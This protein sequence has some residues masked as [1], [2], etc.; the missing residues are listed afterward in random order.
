MSLTYTGRIRRM[1][2]LHRIAIPKQICETLGYEASAP[3]E[4]Y[5][6]NGE[7]AVIIR[8]YNPNSTTMYYGSK[9]EVKVWVNAQ[10]E[11]FAIFGYT[12]EFIT[13]EGKQIGSY[14]YDIPAP[15]RIV[16]KNAFNFWKNYGNSYHYMALPG[17][18]LHL[19]PIVDNDS[20]LLW[21]ISDAPDTAIM[22]LAETYMD[23]F[24][25]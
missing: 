4:F 21:I 3:F 19:Y 17:S 5:V 10:I 2:D 13:P 6:D 14:D 23:K 25:Y 18:N 8:P 7:G 16:M 22:S 9:N 20:P 12:L 11:A 1:D 24:V 15:A